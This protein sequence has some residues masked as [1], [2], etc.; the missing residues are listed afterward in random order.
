[1]QDTARSPEKRRALVTAALGFMQ[2]D[3]W[4][5]SKPPRDADLLD[6]LLNCHGAVSPR[7][8]LGIIPV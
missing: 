5:E 1:M 3:C 6:G 2:L 8:L 7:T 4:N